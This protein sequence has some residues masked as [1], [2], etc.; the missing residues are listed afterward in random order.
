M[1]KAIEDAGLYIT[2]FTHRGHSYHLHKSI[3]RLPV[4]AELVYLGS[5]G[6]YNEV[7]KVFQANPDA[8]IISTR[9]IG[10]KYINDPILS[11][12][13][14]DAVANKDINWVTLWSDFGKSFT[15][16]NT[17]ELFSAYIPPNKYIGI[18]FIREVFNF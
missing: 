8:H 14:S 6:G 12:I 15:A 3:K 16:K 4:S 17:K 1:L 7:V 11:R 13:N 2:Y 5:C 10:S 18:M 9:N